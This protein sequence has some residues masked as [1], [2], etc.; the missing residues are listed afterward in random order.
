MYYILKEW[1]HKTNNAY[2]YL[3]FDNAKIQA[4]ADLT[5]LKCPGQQP[6]V[7]DVIRLAD[8]GEKLDLPAYSHDL[9]RPIEH[10]FG[11]MKH[12]IREELYFAS[13]KYKSPAALQSLVMQQFHHNFPKEQVASDIKGLPLLWQVLSVPSGI[14]FVNFN[15]KLAVGTG[16]DWP[17]AEYR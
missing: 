1:K 5:E 17:N 12:R 10:I 11:T 2:C 15:D 9:N 3:S 8:V 13:W 6:E 4:T 16:G 7:A 14:T